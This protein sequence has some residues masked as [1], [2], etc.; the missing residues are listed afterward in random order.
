MF[1]AVSFVFHFD[2]NSWWK[3]YF[4]I[5]ASYTLMRQFPKTDLQ[6]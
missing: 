6:V 4:F 3:S 5:N 1:D 2:Q